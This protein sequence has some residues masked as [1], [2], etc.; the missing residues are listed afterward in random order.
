[1]TKY[2]ILFIIKVIVLSVP[3]YAQAAK[4]ISFA[5]LGV[6]EGLSQSTIFDIVQDRQGNMWFATYDGLNKYDG[7]DFTV[8]QHDEQNPYSIGCDITRSCMVDSQGN[9]WI[10]TEEGLSLYD[11]SQDKFYNYHYQKT[12]PLAVLWKS[13]RINYFYS[14]IRAKAFCC[15]IPKPN[16]FPTSPYI[17]H[18][19]PYPLPPSAGREIMYI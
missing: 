16:N 12:G 5:H 19:C 2:F 9:L 11:A 8:Y 4:H 18:C 13:A 6:N 3:L 10:G 17:P 15:L 1:M 14:P 7:Y